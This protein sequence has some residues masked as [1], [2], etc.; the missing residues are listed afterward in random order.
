MS[1]GTPLCWRCDQPITT[2]RPGRE[3][4][5]ISISA[6]GAQILLHDEC[7]K[8]SAFVRRTPA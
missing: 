5:K 3:Y 6:G 4:A 1:E 8:L 2:D 7:P